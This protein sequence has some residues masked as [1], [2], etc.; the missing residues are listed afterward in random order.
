LL[1]IDS[2]PVYTS[3]NASGGSYEYIPLL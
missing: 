2:K 1:D 3:Y